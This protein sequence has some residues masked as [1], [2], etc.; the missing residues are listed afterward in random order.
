MVE[1]MLESLE[2]RDVVTKHNS[3]WIG[4]TFLSYEPLKSARYSHAISV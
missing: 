3:S 1:Y 4:A 2:K